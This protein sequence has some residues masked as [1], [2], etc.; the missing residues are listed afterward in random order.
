[1]RYFR[2]PVVLAS[3][4]LLAGCNGMLQIIYP[5]Q[6]ANTV[7]LAVSTADSS[8]T[9]SNASTVQVLASL[10]S[11]NASYPIATYGTGVV[12]DPRSASYTA[13]VTF[14]GLTDGSYYVLVWLDENGN[15]TWDRGEP[16]YLSPDFSLHGVQTLALSARL[17]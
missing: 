11:S 10:F 15:G 6:T 1:M 14:S 3:M 13:S 8:I 16:Y 17:P 7:N 5:N 4:L 9:P 12:Y 2:L